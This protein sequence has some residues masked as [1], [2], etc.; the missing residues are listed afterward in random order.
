MNLAKLTSDDLPLFNGITSDLFP[1]VVLFPVDNSIML[2][3]IKVEMQQRSL[4]VTYLLFV[5]TAVS[6]NTKSYFLHISENCL[7]LCIYQWHTECQQSAV[8]RYPGIDVQAF[9]EIAI[10]SRFIGLYI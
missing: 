10:A 8:Y 4:Q 5:V 1:G 2:S 7:T 6:A 9:T 3:A